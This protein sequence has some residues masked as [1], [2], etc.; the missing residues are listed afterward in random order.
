V[1]A[2]GDSLMVIFDSA[3]DAIAAAVAVQAL[4]ERDNRSVE[5]SKRVLMRIGVSAGDVQ[6][7]DDDF[8]GTPVVEAKR[9]EAAAEPGQILVSDKARSL[10]GSR[11][12]HRL[13][14]VGAFDLKG[15]PEPVNAFAVRW[16]PD[17]PDAEDRPIASPVQPAEQ[18]PPPSRTRR[19]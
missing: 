1:K 18:D 10:A 15:L 13:E 12:G 4:T 3:S 17:V 19:P 9:L 5:E 8:Y 7:V 6:S 11:G 16:V 14:A 2:I